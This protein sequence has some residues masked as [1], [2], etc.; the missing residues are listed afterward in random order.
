MKTDSKLMYLQKLRAK[1][2]TSQANRKI[3]DRINKQIR[4]ELQKLRGNNEK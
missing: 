4:E 2:Y 3:I 1:A